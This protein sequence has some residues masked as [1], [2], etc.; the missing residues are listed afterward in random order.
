MDKIDHTILAL[1]GVI[2]ASLLVAALVLTC[3]ASFELAMA[4]GSAG[5]FLI[6]ALTISTSSLEG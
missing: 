5:L 3:L 1:V 6:V 4:L 2:G